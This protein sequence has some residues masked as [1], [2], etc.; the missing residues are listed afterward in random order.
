MGSGA[1]PDTSA[2]RASSI[3]NS[4]RAPHFSRL[5]RHGIEIEPVEHQPVDLGRQFEMRQFLALLPI[6]FDAGA[7]T[8]M[9]VARLM[10]HLQTRG[11]AGDLSSISMS[12]P[13][14]RSKWTTSIFIPA[15]PP[16]FIGRFTNLA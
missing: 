4:L 11:V 15:A 5:L 9:V 6:E 14:W 8:G 13:P 16:R 1:R 3:R 10:A 7:V 12:L 2:P